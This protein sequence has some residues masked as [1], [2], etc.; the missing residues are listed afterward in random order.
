MSTLPNSLSAAAAI[1][2]TWPESETSVLTIRHL[3]PILRTSAAVSSSCETVRAAATTSAPQLAKRT[4]IARPNPRPAPVMIATLPSSLK[5]SSIIRPPEAGPAH[6]GTLSHRLF[7]LSNTARIRE[8]R[9]ILSRYFATDAAPYPAMLP[10]SR[11][12]TKGCT[13]E[14]G[15]LAASRPLHPHRHRR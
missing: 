10:F 11:Q 7:K 3:R 6:Q 4:A 8:N 2:L 5:L 9:A 13:V 1:A 12:R 15:I 14:K